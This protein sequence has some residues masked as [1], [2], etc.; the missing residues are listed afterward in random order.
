VVDAAHNIDGPLVCLSKAPNAGRDDDAMPEASIV[1]HT[2]GDFLNYHP[3]LHAIVSD[4][5]FRSDGSFQT[6]PDFDQED[7]EAAFQHEVFKMLKKEGKINDAVIDNMLSWYHSGFHVYVGGKIWPDDQAGLENNDHRVG[8]RKGQWGPP[9][10]NV[11]STGELYHIV[12]GHPLTKGAP[13]LPHP[14]ILEF[15]AHISTI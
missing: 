10:N 9:H 4:G 11:H 8:F 7:L 13:S 3:H 2:A 5:C 12:G 6:V 1:V 14:T 15:I